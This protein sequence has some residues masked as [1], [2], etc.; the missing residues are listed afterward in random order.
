MTMADRFSS[1]TEARLELL[2][3][4][5]FLVVRIG[6]TLRELLVAPAC[7]QRSTATTVLALSAE[8]PGPENNGGYL[9]A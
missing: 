7:L 4:T 8:I 1:R 5:L 2:H 6:E 9:R 3:A